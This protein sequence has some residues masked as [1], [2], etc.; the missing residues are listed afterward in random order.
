VKEEEDERSKASGTRNGR[1]EDEDMTLPERNSEDEL[2]ARA[3]MIA[4]N[5][6]SFYVHLG[7]YATV[8]LF[9]FLL[10]WFTSDGG[11]AFPWFAIVA[12]AWGIGV[13]A[14]WIVGFRLIRSPY[15]YVESQTQK[16]FERLKGQR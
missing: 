10:W 7:T 12:L 1:G 2:R 16:E 3:K 6:V 11:D 14:H 4:E 8:N 5:K 13:V 15:T 9:L